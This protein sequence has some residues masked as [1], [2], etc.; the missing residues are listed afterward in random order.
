M[1]VTC[2][3]DESYVF[4]DDLPGK[5]IVWLVSPEGE[6]L[7]GKFVYTNWNVDELKAQ[8]AELDG[9]DKFRIGLNGWPFGSTTERAWNW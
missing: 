1:T 5:F 2:C 9:T 3:R 8:A 7:K 6:F 4:V